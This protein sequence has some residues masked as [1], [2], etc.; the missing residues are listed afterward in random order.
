MIVRD[1]AYLRFTPD[2]CSMLRNVPIG[3]S[4]HES[5]WCEHEPTLPFQQPH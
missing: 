3:M 5:P 4:F 1:G 2:C